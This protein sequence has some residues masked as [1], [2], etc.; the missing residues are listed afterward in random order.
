[1][2]VMW[3]IKRVQ[4]LNIDNDCNHNDVT[5]PTRHIHYTMKMISVAI[6]D[7]VVQVTQSCRMLHM[8]VTQYL[9]YITYVRILKQALLT[10]ESTESVVA[11]LIHSAVISIPGTL[12]N[13]YAHAY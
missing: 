4:I 9:D 3:E 1:M 2:P 11:D 12:I 8:Y 13:V 10:H 5:T 6:E 7:H